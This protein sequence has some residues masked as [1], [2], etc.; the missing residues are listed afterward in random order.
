M[1]DGDRVLLCSDGL[2]AELEDAEIAELLRAHA[3]PQEASDALVAAANDRGS[4][5]NVTVL[6]VE[7]VSGGGDSVKV[8]IP[9]MGQE[10]DGSP[11]RQG[12]SPSPEPATRIERRDATREATQRTA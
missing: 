2:Y 7:V 3:D 6:V 8:D 11:D 12:A 4:H 5:D 10:N 1:R 9:A